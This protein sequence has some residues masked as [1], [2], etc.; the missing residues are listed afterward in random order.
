MNAVR[1]WLYQII[2]YLCLM[3]VVLQII[4]DTGLKKYVRFF[5]GLLFIL[6][7]LRPVGELAGGNFEGR[8]ELARL[9]QEYASWKEEKSGLDQLWTEDGDE[10][11]EKELLQK[12]TA[13][14]AEYGETEFIR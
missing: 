1:E 11:Y 8:L 7:V 5:L 9:K 6:V 4:P 14:G 3:T 13:L 10:E 2:F 12:I